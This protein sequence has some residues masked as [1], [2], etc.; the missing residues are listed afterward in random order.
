M[1]LLMAMIKKMKSL[2]PESVQVMMEIVMRATMESDIIAFGLT[3][4][5][6]RPRSKCRS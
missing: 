5:I 1:V 3:R 2:K 6:L 4:V